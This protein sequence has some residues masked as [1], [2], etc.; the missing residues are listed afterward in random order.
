[1]ATIHSKS[2]TVLLAVAPLLLF[3]SVLICSAQSAEPGAPS[4]S[5]CWSK[6]GITGHVTIGP[7][8]P[9]VRPDLNCDDAPFQTTIAVWT[10]P[11]RFLGK[12]DTDS[13]GHFTV[14]LRP[15]TYVLV[16]SV[17][18]AE[19]PAPDEPPIGIIY[20]Y[21]APLQVTVEPRQFTLVAIKYDSGIQ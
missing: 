2:R 11:G 4:K 3:L 14:S 19:P 8:C 10:R 9:V 6:S 18:E 1:M 15:G 12:V 21:A 17:P 16:P 7:T 20:P 13:Q 5:K